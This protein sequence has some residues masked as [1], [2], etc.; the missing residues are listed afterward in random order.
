MLLQM[1]QQLAQTHNKA[2]AAVE[3]LQAEVQ[4]QLAGNAFLLL[5]M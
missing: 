3:A 4:Q 2:V 1:T 5:F